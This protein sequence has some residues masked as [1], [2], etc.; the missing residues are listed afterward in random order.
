MT[1]LDHSGNAIARCQSA[2][3]PICLS[4]CLS[5]TSRYFI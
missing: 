1:F 2:R 4:V 3:P 5:V